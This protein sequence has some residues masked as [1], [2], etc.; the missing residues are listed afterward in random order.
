M[1]MKKR[2]FCLLLAGVMAASVSACGQKAETPVNT[3]AEAAEEAVKEEPLEAAEDPEEE[4]EA[5]TETEP[6]ATE[7]TVSGAAKGAPILCTVTKSYYETAED[8]TLLLQGHCSVPELAGD[9]AE[10]YP[11]LA[12]ALEKDGEKFL[13]DFSAS[14]NESIEMAKSDYQSA[15]ERFGEGN[16]HYASESD[17]LVQ[18]VDDKVTSYFA[19]GYDFTGGAHGMYG[20]TG[21]TYDNLTGE[22][23]LLTDVL[24]DTSGLAGI[25]K[26]E[27]EAAYSDVEFDDL[28]GAL[29]AYDVSITEEAPDADSELGYHFP[30]NW[31]LSGEGVEFYFEPYSLAAYAAGD[32]KITLSYEKYADIMKPDYLPTKGS[33]YMV[34][35]KNY[36][37]GLDVNGDG[38]KDEVSVE[39]GYSDDYM[40]IE[41]ISL[42]VGEKSAESFPYVVDAGDA[43]VTGYYIVTGDGKRYVY[44]LANEMNDY[45]ELFVFDLSGDS[46]V[47]V[48]AET[49]H[50]SV[51]DY[52]EDG[53]FAELLLSDPENL[54][55]CS[56]FDFLSSFTAFRYY[57]P[58]ADGKPVSDDT[59]YYVLTDAAQEA[60]VAKTDLECRLLSPDGA[61]EETGETAVIK[62]G[63][64]FSAFR[65]DGE[66]ALDVT[67]SDG[68][69]GRLT[70]TDNGHPCEINAIKDTDCVETT[71]Y[72]G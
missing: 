61:M 46:P 17:V 57:H 13:S 70:I 49:Y 58:G 66:T 72:A 47:S 27:L 62:K 59:Y 69:I 4:P 1:I 29:A 31:A 20:Q 65:T 6:A 55:L 15:P 42:M 21:Y 64:T 7:E 16:L 25:L 26:E 2:I 24:S 18:R 30:Y 23:L 12:A 28:E 71:W 8:G 45:Q 3:A 53:A 63:D 35:F 9:S 50:R 36:L 41:T 48:A 52:R 22:R 40:T 38:E 14:V 67:L 11:E 37:S 39:F 60:L 34:S 32:Q 5:E 33:P 19:S 44:L 10:L 68:R 51:F 43:D 56:N 54:P